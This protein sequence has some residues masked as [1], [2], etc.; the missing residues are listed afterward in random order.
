M[1]EFVS[2]S[3]AETV[4]ILKRTKRGLYSLH[5]LQ[6][7]S[8]CDRLS[9][10]ASKENQFPPSH[11]GLK[12]PPKATLARSQEQAMI[13]TFINFQVSFIVGH[14]KRPAF[15]IEDDSDLAVY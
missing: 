12:C 1:N 6:S 10:V 5:G 4:E 9:M 7:A 8:H 14:S 2:V 13:H 11:Q 3:R 15:I